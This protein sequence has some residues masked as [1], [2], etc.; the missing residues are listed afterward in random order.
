[1]MVM[2]TIIL[3]V[4]FFA[5]LHTTKNN[6]EK[7]STMLLHQ[8]LR[9]KNMNSGPDHSP[10]DMQKPPQDMRIPTMTVN[11]NSNGEITVLQNRLYFLEEQDILDQLNKISLDGKIKTGEISS[12]NLRY[13]FEKI[14]K[15]NT[16]IAFIDI[17][18]EKAVLKN[19]ILSSLV[20]GVSAI[21]LFL[22]LSIFLSYWAIKPVK[23]TWDQQRQFVADA[24]HELKTPLTVI[25]SN[26][27]MLVL[28][29]TALDK[30]N[31]FR[32][33]NIKTESMR[34]K[35]LVEEMLTLAKTDT[36]T[37]YLVKDKVNLSDIVEDSALLYESILYD[38]N[39]VLITDIKHE[40]FI[41]GDA[42]KLRQL[43]DILLDNAKKYS[44]IEQDINIKLSIKSKKTI[45]SVTN[46]GDII[47]QNELTK[48][49]HRFYRIDK[50]RSNNGGFG[51]G[52]SIAQNIVKEHKGDIWAE[53][54]EQDGITFFASFNVL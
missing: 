11:I 12:Y 30:K 26:T 50:S 15:G 47:P 32:V 27:D 53:S 44:P 3:L 31:T 42:S 9:P 29:K 38:D 45:L 2:V 21:V 23:K 7:Q 48:I 22:F 18:T 6:L 16:R 36:D 35:N 25:I 51:L 24:S 34:M 41:E 37:P 13:V 39:K 54:N 40:I 1:M 14:E 33:D 8:S 10:N 4:V 17:S 52:L 46:K 5:V 49:F 19:L 28:N 43:V 20:I